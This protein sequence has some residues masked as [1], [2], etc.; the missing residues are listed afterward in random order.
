M[1]K[2]KSY[3]SLIFYTI[4]SLVILIFIWARNIINMLTSIKLIV[5]IIILI[6][7]ASIWIVYSRKK[8]INR[9]IQKQLEKK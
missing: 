4:I 7:K 9:T 5:T 3:L 1:E 6:I 8:V 2:N